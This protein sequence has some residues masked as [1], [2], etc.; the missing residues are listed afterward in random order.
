VELADLPTPLSP[1]SPAQ[2]A[3][4]GSGVRGQLAIQPGI[5]EQTGCYTA[6]ARTSRHSPGTPWLVIKDVVSPGGGLYL[7]PP[8]PPLGLMIEFLPNRM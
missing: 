4:E 3:G 6:N 8:P 7:M 2:T 5:L 1:L